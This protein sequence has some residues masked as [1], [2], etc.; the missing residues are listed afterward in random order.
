MTIPSA[1][2]LELGGKQAVSL[3]A[4]HIFFVLVSTLLSLGFGAWAIRLY[5]TDEQIASLAIGVVSLAGGV[6]LMVYGRWFL[7]KLQSVSYL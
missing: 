4:F 1:Q 5:R 6:A 2:Q 3:K 7:K